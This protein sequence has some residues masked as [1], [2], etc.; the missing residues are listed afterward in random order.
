MQLLLIRAKVTTR[1]F[2][3]GDC[4]VVKPLRTEPILGHEASKADSASDDETLRQTYETPA[5]QASQRRETSINREYETGVQVRGSNDFS[6]TLEGPMMVSIPIE[7][8]IGSEFRSPNPF[9]S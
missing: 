7:Y 4:I 1:P 2:T 8:P 9:R 6:Y 3:R 5:A